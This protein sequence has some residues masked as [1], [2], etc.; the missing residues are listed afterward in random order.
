MRVGIIGLGHRLGYL[1]RV[2]QAC[3]PGFSVAGYVDTSPAGLTGM[4]KAGVDAGK[5]YETL[6]ALMQAEKPDLLMIG[7]P[8]HLHLPLLRAALAHDVKIFCEKPVVTTLDET[9]EL[10]KLL[11]AHGGPSRVMVGLV[12]RY[13][14]LYIDL[15]R[16]VTEGALGNIV[17]IEASEHIAPWHG[18]FFMRDWRRHT[19]YTGGYMLEKCCHDLDLYQGIV[20]ARAMRVASFGGRKSFVPANAADGERE[21]HHKM[22]TGW[23]SGTRVFDSDGDIV[24]Y[25]T[26][27]IEYANG[28][29]MTFHA[30]LNV[31]N[32]FRRFAVMGT[33]GT[34]EGDFVRKYFRLADA[35]SNEVTLDKTYSDSALSHHYGADEMMAAD[36]AAHVSYG[37]ALPV[38]VIDALVAGVTAMMIDEARRTGAVVDLKPIWERFDALLA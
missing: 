13:A 21:L 17:S 37:A 29:A 9:F 38:S 15:S 31:P 4:Q 25:Q 3:V 19:K 18:G 10:L 16:A 30:N 1:A 35:R 26:A 28:T 14:P 2:F 33:K 20:G 12:L 5:S 23:E 6:D 36:I 8:N 22:R 27:I 7:T 32:H 34:A 24:D 11:K